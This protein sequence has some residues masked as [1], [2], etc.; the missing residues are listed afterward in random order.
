MTLTIR[1]SI[2]SYHLVAL[3]VLPMLM[4]GT[5]MSSRSSLSRRAMESM[6]RIMMRR[7][8]AVLLTLVD[9]EM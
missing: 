4:M 2:N 6:P 5:V 7:R 8:K 3:M 9:L 1:G